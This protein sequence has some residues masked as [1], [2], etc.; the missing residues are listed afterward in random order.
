MTYVHLACAKKSDKLDMEKKGS[1][2]CGYCQNTGAI[3]HVVGTEDVYSTVVNGIRWDVYEGIATRHDQEQVDVAREQHREQRMRK[4]FDGQRGPSW[5]K[6]DDYEEFKEREK[7]ESNVPE[8]EETEEIEAETVEEKTEA[9][10]AGVPD[11][12]LDNTD[13]TPSPPAEEDVDEIAELEAKLAALKG[14]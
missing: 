11:E 6:I 8:Q 9:E 7:G 12:A 1:G 10:K 13:V 5:E 3:Y 2:T 14:E 4:R